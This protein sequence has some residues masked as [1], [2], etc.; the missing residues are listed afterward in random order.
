MSRVFAGWEPG[1]PPR[2]HGRDTR[3]GAR[4][5]VWSFAASDARGALQSGALAPPF[6]S[7]PA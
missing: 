7:L 5:L 4:V 1:R 6:S 3:N 2:R